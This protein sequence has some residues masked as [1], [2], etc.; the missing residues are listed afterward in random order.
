MNKKILATVLA[1]TISTAHLFELTP[2]ENGTKASAHVNT[3]EIVIVVDESFSFLDITAQMEHSN[4]ADWIYRMLY[5]RL[6]EFDRDGN[7]MYSL[8]TSITFSYYEDGSEPVDLIGA[9]FIGDYNPTSSTVVS[10]PPGWTSATDDIDWGLENAL[11]F[12]EG[13]GIIL[14]IKLREDVFFSNGM[15][16]NINVFEHMINVVKTQSL[17][18]SLIYKQWSPLAEIEG[19]GYVRYINDYEGEI[20]LCFTDDIPFGFIDFIITIF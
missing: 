11:Y 8:A 10:P 6:L 20:R 7:L 19:C 12:D 1:V 14:N 16:F 2:I 17:S 5:D 9:G 3:G 13:D 15:P 4:S 18:S